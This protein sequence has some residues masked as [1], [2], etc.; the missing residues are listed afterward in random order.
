VAQGKTDA[1]L[2]RFVVPR[3]T[4]E[5]E[6]ERAGFRIAGHQDFLPGYAMWRVYVLCK[7]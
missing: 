1:N 6:F 2:N 4:I 7:A 5:A 3:A